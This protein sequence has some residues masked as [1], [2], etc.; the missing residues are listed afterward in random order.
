[1]NCATPESPLVLCGDNLIWSGCQHCRYRGNCSY[2]RDYVYQ[3]ALRNVACRECALAQRLEG[4]ST[5]LKRAVTNAD[6]IASL[7]QADESLVCA[8]DNAAYAELAMIDDL[9]SL[10]PA[11]P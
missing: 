3:S 8:L 7:L 11:Y 9:S 5:R 2:L 10:Q 6:R 4:E 1:M